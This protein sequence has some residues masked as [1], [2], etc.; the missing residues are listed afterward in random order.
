MADK[1][2]LAEFD[3][4]VS[5]LEKS[6]SE[7][8]AKLDELIASQKELTKAGK[9]ADEAFVINAAN[10]RGLRREYNNQIKVLNE[11]Y[12]ATS[13]NLPLEHQ[14]NEVMNRE[15]KSVNDLRKQISDLT[16]ARN[17][18]NLTTEEGQKQLKV[19]NDAIDA[20]NAKLKTSVSV[21]EQQKMNVG[22]YA[23]DI[24]QAAGDLNLF[25]DAQGAVNKVLD[26]GSAVVN[27]AKNDLNNLG[28]AF[29]VAESA[30]QK[31]VAGLKMLRVALAAT[32]VGLL[33]VALASIVTYLKSTE[34]G[35]NTLNRVLVPLKTVL[36]GLVAVIQDLG[37]W[38][39]DAFTNPKKAVEDLKNAIQPLRDMVAGVLTLDFKRANKGW[40]DMKDRVEGVVES[41]R[42]LLEL[43]R[44]IQR[45]NENIN[46][47]EIALIRSGSALKRTLEEQ[48]EI[49]RDASK[50]F[51]E[52]ETAAKNALSLAKALSDLELSHLDLKI[53]RLQKE[54]TINGNIHEDNVELAK[55]ETE[56]EERLARDARLRSRLTIRLNSIRK[57]DEKDINKAV[58]DRI[59]KLN[60]ELELLKAQSDLESKTLEERHELE[61]QFSDKSLEILKAELNAKLISQEKYE[62]AVLNLQRES[63]KR[64][65][66]IALEALNKEQDDRFKDIEIQRALSEKVGVAKIEEERKILEKIKEYNA[67]YQHEL[68]QLGLI[69]EEEYRRAIEDINHDFDIQRIES[70][71]ALRQKQLENS[72]ALRQMEFD[73]ELLALESLTQDK[74][75][76]EELRIEQAKEIAVQDALNRFEDEALLQQALLNINQESANAI[77]ELN[78]QK[79][80]VI[81]DSKIKL[82]DATAQIIGEETLLGKAAAIASATMN[83]YQGATKALATLPPPASF[84]TAAA[85]ITSGLSSVAKIAGIGAKSSSPKI[86]ATKSESKQ[87]EIQHLNAIPPFATGGKVVGGIPI[88]R[89]NGDNILATLKLGEVVLNKNQQRMLGGDAT[90]RAIGVPGFASG[91]LVGG[92]TVRNSINRGFNKEMAE[93][94]SS[95]VMQGARIG[96]E[97]GSR[98]GLND[99]ATEAYIDRISRS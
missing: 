20:N 66:D 67:S 39:V 22:N 24:K 57:G 92:Q 75:A 6:A 36:G 87:I 25:G 95:S 65:A 50:S 49:S 43:G 7:V 44:E 55:L 88:N 72:Q 26:A 29:N 54:Q 76:I 28:F 17:N 69:N 10:I 97:E 70:E 71:K 82:L 46:A 14:I 63:A 41:T 38:L 89:S 30:N 56:R 78:R 80:D 60:D 9:S 61:Q 77:A 74:F 86:S 52:R 98:E 68:F 91:G 21:Y 8:K 12:D 90:F 33:V 19:I 59:K 51:E 27:K 40:E 53:E 93:L 73:A 3:I 4:D 42:D 47:S 31:V 15:T 32:G 64:Q 16:K 5:D 81:L 79:D 62:A 1:I 85:T 48:R 58:D 35:I 13:K 84:I 11:V 45:L 2:K 23:N 94:I 37:K 96:T 18:V 83:T 99:R 34:E